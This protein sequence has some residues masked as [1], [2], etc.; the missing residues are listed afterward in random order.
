L[1]V[2]IKKFYRAGGVSTQFK[3]VLSDIELPSIWNCDSAEVG[4]S[5][6]PDAL[7]CDEVSS[8]VFQNLNRV[9]PC[10]A[11]LRQLS[12]NRVAASKDFDY[13]RQDIAEFLKQQAD[14][15][16]SLN[17]A[18]RQAE[19]KT[20][21]ARAEAIRKEQL[22]RKKSGE[23]VYEITLQNADL[24][25]LQPPTVKTNYAA[26]KS[27]PAAPAFDDDTEPGE[28]ADA[29]AIDP[30]LDEARRILADYISLLNKPPIVSRAP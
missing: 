14:K 9:K 6:L 13:I 16:L 25:Q 23:K 12:A 22:S 2:T 30:P 8:A 18:E 17:L 7:P 28:S 19:Q 1:K 15:S 26:A 5:A 11:Q 21:T 10:L 24:A 20:R 4:E 29:A 27:A 3:G